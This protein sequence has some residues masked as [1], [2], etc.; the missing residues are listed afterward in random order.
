MSRPTEVDK[1]MIR[2]SK[3]VEQADEYINEFFDLKTWED[4]VKFLEENFN[5]ETYNSLIK[6][7]SLTYFLVG[8]HPN[9][10][11][12]HFKPTKLSSVATI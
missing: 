12:I 4:K 6:F 11:R 2:L 10:R 8:M 7:M 9:R 1:A 3:T 5:I